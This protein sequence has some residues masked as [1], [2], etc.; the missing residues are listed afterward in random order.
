MPPMWPSRSRSSKPRARRLIQRLSN[1]VLNVQRQAARASGR[2]NF[3]ANTG[4]ART[5]TKRPRYAY[6]SHRCLGRTAGRC[7]HIETHSEGLASMT[8]GE[9]GPSERAVTMATALRAVLFSRGLGAAKAEV[10]ELCDRRL[11]KAV[12]RAIKLGE[13]IVPHPAPS[14]AF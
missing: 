6:G 11:G 9:W 2:Q 5:Y 3:G 10:R 12:G 7:A 1:P 4:I 13:R 8:P 14:P